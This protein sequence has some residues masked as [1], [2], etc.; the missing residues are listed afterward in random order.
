MPRVKTG[1]SVINVEQ[2]DEVNV[3]DGGIHEVGEAGVVVAREFASVVGV[4]EVS[5]GDDASFQPFL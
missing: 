4:V 1:G 2:Q 3:S 5:E